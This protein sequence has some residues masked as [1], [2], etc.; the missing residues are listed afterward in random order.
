MIR[1]D[2]EWQGTIRCDVRSDLTKCDTNFGP[3]NN[4]KV[5]KKILWDFHFILKLTD[6][7]PKKLQSE[8]RCLR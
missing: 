8:N 1:R 5:G 3:G 6:W 4:L 2:K 7:S